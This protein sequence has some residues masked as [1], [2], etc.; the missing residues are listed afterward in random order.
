MFEIRL[1]NIFMELKST[2]IIIN[3]VLRILAP[4]G[5]FCLEPLANNADTY[6]HAYQHVCIMYRIIFNILYYYI[7]FFINIC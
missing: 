1:F 6:I 7:L 5:Y 4:R 2:I 3:G